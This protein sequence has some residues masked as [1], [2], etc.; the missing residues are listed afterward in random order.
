MDGTRI[1]WNSYIEHGLTDGTQILWNSQMEH[2][3]AF[4]TKSK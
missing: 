1:L 2:T 3:L 4:Q